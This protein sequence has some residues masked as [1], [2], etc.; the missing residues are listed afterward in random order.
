MGDL[1]GAYFILYLLTYFL[2][3]IIALIWGCERTG[4]VFIMNLFLGWTFIGW[5]WAFVWAVSPKQQQQNIIINNHVS[6]DR[7]INPIITQP[8][9]ENFQNFTNTQLPLNKQAQLESSNIKSHQD[10]IIQL[11]QMKQLLDNGI[12]TQNEFDE[13]KSTIL[14]S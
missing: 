7:I 5:V 3:T 12:L 11:Q 13:Q 6:A 1:L 2:P 14:A 4:S 9:Q 8:A 10:K